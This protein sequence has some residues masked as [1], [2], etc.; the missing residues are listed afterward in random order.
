M[1]LKTKPANSQTRTSFFFCYFT[2]FLLFIVNLKGTQIYFFILHL[3][4]IIKINLLA[5]RASTWMTLTLF[6]HI[7][8]N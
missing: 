3:L 6:K 1:P 5:H 4:N 7:V 2:L 8:C